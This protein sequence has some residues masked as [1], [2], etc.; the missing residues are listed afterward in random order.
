MCCPLQMLLLLVDSLSVALENP[1]NKILS[2][3]LQNELTNNLLLD[4]TCAASRLFVTLLPW[5]LDWG[6]A[7]VFDPND[8]RDIPWHLTSC[9]TI[10]PGK[11]FSKVTITQRLDGHVS[12]DGVGL[13]LHHVF[14]S[15]F[16]LLLLNSWP[17]RYSFLLLPFLFFSPAYWG[18]GLTNTR[19]SSP[20]YRWPLQVIF[21]GLHLDMH[22][23]VLQFNR[24][25]LIATL[26]FKVMVASYKYLSWS[27][28][29][30]TQNCYIKLIH[31]WGYTVNSL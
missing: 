23:F 12:H 17:M 20:S 11:L 14:F 8:Q 26:C 16:P 31:W 3:V 18:V 24:L 29:N 25:G 28:V 30:N 10:E 6:W 21:E 2:I 4:S 9:S 15:F 5:W 22:I 7:K 13:F 1:S 19:F 27:H